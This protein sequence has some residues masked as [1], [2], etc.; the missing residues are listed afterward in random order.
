MRWVEALDATG[1]GGK[2]NHGL[3]G[4]A[5]AFTRTVTENLLRAFCQGPAGLARPAVDNLT[6][7]YPGVPAPS[8]GV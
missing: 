5:G 3:D 7:H 6:V 4:R 1:P 2:G 8:P